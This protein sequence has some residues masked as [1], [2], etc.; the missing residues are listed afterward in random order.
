M[1]ML[2]F[3]TRTGFCPRPSPLMKKEWNAPSEEK[4]SRKKP[5]SKNTG[6][7]SCFL[8]LLACIVPHEIKYYNQH[9]ND[10]HLLSIVCVSSYM[11]GSKE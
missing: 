8:R 4:G 3:E 6:M 2:L 1:D 7:N 5:T 11:I 9:A 10:N